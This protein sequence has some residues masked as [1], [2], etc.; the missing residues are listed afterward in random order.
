[1]TITVFAPAHLGPGY[2]F[3][4]VGLTGPVPN[5]DIFQVGVRVSGATNFLVGG[6]QVLNGHTFAIVMLGASDLSNLACALDVYV[7]PG[8]TVQAEWKQM[9]SN[10]T[11]VDSGTVT[12]LLW[13][14]TG[15]VGNLV[16]YFNQLGGG[17]LLGEIRDAVIHTFPAT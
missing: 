6:I 10:L 11:V 13:D 2:I 17:S 15:G 14:P 16:T 9:H 7:A 5:D 12:G 1:L 8:A 3:Q 4:A